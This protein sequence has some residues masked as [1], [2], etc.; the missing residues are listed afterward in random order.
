MKK[1]T[2]KLTGILLLGLLALG[3]Q[4]C[5]TANDAIN[6]TKPATGVQDDSYRRSAVAPTV[7]TNALTSVT[8]TTAVSGG[9]IT[10]TGSTHATIT[11][12]GVCWGTTA[13]PTTANQVVAGGTATSFSVTLTGLPATYYVR[14]YAT[15][16][17]GMT[18][19]GNQITGTGTTVTPSTTGGTGSYTPASPI[20]LSGVSGQTISG[21]FIGNI[22]GVAITLANCHDMIITGMKISHTVGSAIVLTNCYNI[23]ITHC[24]IDSVKSGVYA[25]S[26]TGGIV[27][28]YNDVKNIQGPFPQAQMLQFDNCKGAGNSISYNTCDNQPGKSSPEDIINMWM[29]TGTAA[30]PIMINGNK[31]RGGGP[32]SSGGG[33]I[34]G[35]GGGGYQSASNNILVDPGQ[36][37]MSIAGGSNSLLA[38]NQIYGRS[39]SFTNVGLYL[40]NQYAPACANNTV[41]NNR[42][43]FRYSAGQLNDFYNGATVASGSSPLATGTV[44]TNNVDDQTLTT[45][46]LPAVLFG[47]NK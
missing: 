39:Q 45:S 20:S 15:N 35:D 27:F 47:T 42:V 11:A 17:Y 37:G 2:E 23:T 29:S 18:G 22:S 32:S 12:S 8:T 30:S 14:A 10:N 5:S 44:W 19:Y 13:N 38:S 3:I 4:S 9:N 28:N 25:V 40:W 6:P 24:E 21:K 26:C 34:M 33:I 43:N 7:S 31:I 41:Q 1:R 16:S 46:I 36:Y